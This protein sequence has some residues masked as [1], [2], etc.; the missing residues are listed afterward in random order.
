MILQTVQKTIQQSNALV[1]SK[2]L[3]VGV[4]GG[5]DSV[6]LLHM[7]K[8]LR[9]SLGIDLHVASLNHGIRGDAG[10]A[11]L[12]FVGELAGRWQLPSTLSQADVPRLARELGIG[13]EAA[14]RRARYDFLAQVAAAQSS[15]CV[16]VGHHALDQAETILMHIVRG[17]GQQGLQGMPPVSDLPGHPG[18]RLIRP[19]L[20][21]TRLQ[22]EAY[23]A[24]HELPFRHDSSN[25]DRAYSRN[26]LR[27]EVIS[28]L[29]GLNPA[30]IA[31]LT[32][33][34]E[35][36]AVD[37]D[38]MELYFETQV[39]SLLKTTDDHWSMSKQ[40]FFA[41][42]PAMQR[43]FLRAGFQRLTGS[44]STL[45]HGVTRELLDWLPQASVGGRRHLG[46]SLQLRIG[47]G[48]IFIERIGCETNIHNFRVI[49]SDSDIR[50]E[51]EAPYSQHGIKICTLSQD[52]EEEPKGTRLLLPLPAQLRLR[53]RRPGDRFKPKGMNGH[54]RKLKDWM[55]DR[56][57]PREIR[58]Q[59]PLL[60]AD[61][62][63]IAICLGETWHLADLSQFDLGEH[64][65][66]TVMLQ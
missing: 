29:Q 52:F 14:A 47:Y 28:R 16:A 17:S 19:L 31:A 22:L 1:G 46:A 66:K 51:T 63:I 41:L 24:K 48:A 10:Q 34:G 25:E 45:Q 40:D 57:I 11:D 64:P 60:C 55:I 27:H 59:I 30:V 23:C 37:E 42:H 9:S 49:P 39:Q 33:L 3:I 13:I 54:S 56:K 44:P 53:T 18:I 35:S 4:S 12:D 5:C 21:I 6:A 26:F 62:Q 65:P 8:R 43:R 61:D 58:D 15:D 2:K 20:T 36:V 7:M 50:I 38:F 32:R